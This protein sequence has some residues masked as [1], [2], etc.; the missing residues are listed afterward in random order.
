MYLISIPYLLIVLRKVL[1][2][3]IATLFP[4]HELLRLGVGSFAPA[5][6]VILLRYW[7]HAPDLVMLGLAGTIYVGLA[8]FFLSRL[9]FLDLP[10]LYAQAVARV[11]QRFA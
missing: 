11:R 3:P 10:G 5:V 7:I 6:L 9:G 1:N 4:W 2:C 8:G